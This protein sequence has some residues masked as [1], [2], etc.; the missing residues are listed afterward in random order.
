MAICSLAQ[1]LSWTVRSLPPSS[2]RSEL[3]RAAT[4]ETRFSSKSDSRSRLLKFPVATMSNFFG[5]RDKMTVPE[6]AVLGH[7][8][9]V[10]GV[11]ALRYL[12][13]ACP[14]RPWEIHRM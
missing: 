4:I 11:G 5:C 12:V 8:N 13:V 7:D 1:V 14:V 6:V 2:T 9:T 3:S 10:L